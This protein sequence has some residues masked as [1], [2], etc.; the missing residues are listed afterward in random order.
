[1]EKV[2]AVDWTLEF[3]SALNAA[4]GGF[5]LVFSIGCAV[6]IG[7]LAKFWKSES[8]A[9][10]RLALIAGGVIYLSLSSLGHLKQQTETLEEL[11]KE[12]R[13]VVE[14]L[15]NKQNIILNKEADMPARAYF[16]LTQA[17]IRKASENF[18]YFIISVQNND[19]L[20]ENVVIHLLV[21]GE[22]LDP[23]KMPLHSYKEES[24]NPVGPRGEI[25][26]TWGPIEIKENS[27]PAFV[28]FQ[29]KY[30]NHL[31]NQTYSQVM[32]F[33]FGG[34]NQE[35]SYIEE[36]FHASRDDKLMIERYMEKRGLSKL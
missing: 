25:S 4:H 15:E 27:P 21:L 30:T 17:A 8:A 24:A 5:P 13:K 26:R 6:M 1:M 14:E 19:F 7:A 3:L 12:Q 28:V 9:P 35:G 20:A 31:Q 29:I 18:R 22:S 16:T 32:F 33:K 10:W 11:I 2:F 23:K 34:S 36:F